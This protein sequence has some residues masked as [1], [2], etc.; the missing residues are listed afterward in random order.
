MSA[1]PKTA[2]ANQ[3][4]RSVPTAAF[5]PAATPAPNAPPATESTASQAFPHIGC[6]PGGRASGTSAL[7][8]TPCTRDSTNRPNA[9]GYRLSRSERVERSSARPARPAAAATIA[10]R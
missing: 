5:A 3:S 7:R 6:L 1:Q 9:N 8:L 2:A 4:A 10:P